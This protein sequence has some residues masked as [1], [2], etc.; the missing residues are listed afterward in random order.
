MTAPFKPFER[1]YIRYR[2]GKAIAAYPERPDN[3][4]GVHNYLLR[5]F[6]GKEAAKIAG[7]AGGFASARGMS[8]QAR[9]A[10]A[11]TAAR[12]MWKKKKSGKSFS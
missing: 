2:D 3:M 11:R 12:A 1:L 9:V 6:I 7:R 5:E 10:R 4:Q 8:K